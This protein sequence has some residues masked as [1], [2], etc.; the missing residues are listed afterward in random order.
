MTPRP[1]GALLSVRVQARAS[2]DEIVG[3][4]GDTLRVRVS[5]PPV[6]GQANMAI[7]TLIA[8]ALGVALAS[9]ELVRGERSRDKVVRVAGLVVS[10]I[11]A[12][13][14]GVVAGALLLVAASS[15]AMADHLSLD[16]GA[17]AIGPRP[18]D[19]DVSLRTED[20]GFHVGGR[21][22][23]FGQAL[24]AWLRGRLRDGGVVLDGQLQGDRAWNFRIEADPLPPS[25]R[26]D[27]YPGSI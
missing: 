19:A 7:R 6:E 1:D 26:I 14:A 15:P 10:D 21:V 18:F 8:R 9:V 16:P 25:L 12:R 17:R 27:V 13:L 22:S 20:G 5:A 23:G 4:Q 11:R 3:W 24:G 2:R